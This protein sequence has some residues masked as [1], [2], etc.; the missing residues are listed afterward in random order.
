M[1]PEIT[2]PDAGIDKATLRMA[3]R[4]LSSPSRRYRV[5]VKHFKG[6]H[7]YIAFVVDT[8]TGKMVHAETLYTV[9]PRR[10]RRPARSSEGGREAARIEADWN[11]TD[12]GDAVVIQTWKEA[13]DAF[14][15]FKKS[16][17]RRSTARIYG[18]YVRRFSDYLGEAHPRI[19]YLEEITISVAR[20]YVSWRRKPVENYQTSL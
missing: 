13:S 5:R 19:Q 17:R 18:Q 12:S 20:D 16:E 9:D 1:T 15:A 8:W 14:L 10:G 3:R 6:R 11:S 2:A 7:R 4:R